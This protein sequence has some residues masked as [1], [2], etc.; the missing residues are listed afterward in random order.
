MKTKIYWIAKTAVFIALLVA[1][2]AVTKPLGQYVTG[3]AVNL[4]LILAA[5][6]GGVASGVTVAIISPFMAF[7]LGIGPALFPVVPFIAVGN[8]VLVIIWCLICRLNIKP[9][10]VTYIISTAVAALLK[11]GVLYL[12]ISQVAVKFI[13]SAK[14]STIIAMFGI[15]QLFT[16]AIA[17]AAACIILPVLVKAIGGMESR[18]GLEK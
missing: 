15:T 4:V 8:V 10:I 6:L 2:Q 17:G 5:V 3:S 9:K 16:A 1:L 12:L 11:F 7:L 14:A 13:P 18:A